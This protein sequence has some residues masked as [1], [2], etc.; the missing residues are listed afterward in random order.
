MTD[1]SICIK[2]PFILFFLHA[3]SNLYLNCQ[4]TGLHLDTLILI[5]VCNVCSNIWAKARQNQQNDIYAQRRLRSASAS[6]QSDQSSLCAHWIAKSPSCLPADSENSYQTGQIPRLIWV[7]AGH[8]SHFVLSCCS[9]FENYMKSL[10][11]AFNHTAEYDAMISDYFRQQFSS[12]VSQLPLRYGMNPHQ[13]PAQISTILSKLPLTGIMSR[14]M[15]TKP[16][17]WPVRPVK[18]QISLSIRPVWS[19]S[20]LSTWRNLWSSATYWAHSEDWSVWADAQPDLSLCW[21]HK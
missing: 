4:S 15:T 13:K 11:Q 18:T 21:A 5:P 8:T 16:T 20:W 9:S 14:C 19:E 6:S 12:G 1:F 10:W 17:K 2:Q 7:F 3:L